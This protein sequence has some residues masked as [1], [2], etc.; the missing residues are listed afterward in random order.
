MAWSKPRTS[1]YGNTKVEADGLT[2]DSKREYSR[3]RDLQLLER[4]GEIKNLQRQVPFPLLVDEQLIGK[5]I[6][7]HVYYDTRTQSKVIEDVKGV[8]TA[9]FKWKA[10]H[11]LAQYKVKILIVK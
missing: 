2:F 3:W 11:V 5:Y 6:A 10:K 8:E 1:K 4:A 9:L 7:D